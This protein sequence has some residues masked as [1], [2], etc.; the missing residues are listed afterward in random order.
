[1]GFTSRKNPCQKGEGV[2]EVGFHQKPSNPTFGY[3]YVENESFPGGPE[4]PMEFRE[5]FFKIIHMAEGE[6]HGEEIVGGILDGHGLG[7]GLDVFAGE[8]LLRFSDHAGARFEAG[9]QTFGS[10]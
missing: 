2:L 5:R 6:S 7:A 10:D 4:D 9:N 8:E 3:S 1:G